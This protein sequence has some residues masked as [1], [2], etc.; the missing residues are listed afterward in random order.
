MTASALDF[1]DAGLLRAVSAGE[2][3]LPGWRLRYSDGSHA[4][5]DLAA[6]CLLRAGDD[7]LLAAATGAVLDIGC[8]PGRLT[9]ALTW[10]G[11]PSLGIDISATAVALTRAA[12]AAALRRSV[13]TRI[14]GS[15]QWQTLL[16]AD[17]NIG[18]GGDPVA[19]LSRARE[20]MAPRG[21]LLV[22]L[23][24]HGTGA[25][26]V[27]RLENDEGDAGGWFRWAHVGPAGLEALTERA[28]LRTQRLWQAHDRWFAEVTR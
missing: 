22:E 6:W 1:Y 27:V 28:G 10:R 26:V 19:L 23:D 12:G 13:F 17:G 8:G 3:A 20:L 16:L 9:A 18:I 4:T 11:V 21:S 5:V 25:T 24:H 7:E 14:P 2:A 15:G